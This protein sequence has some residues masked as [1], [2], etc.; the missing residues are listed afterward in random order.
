[1]DINKLKTGMREVN[2]NENNSLYLLR[3][4]FVF[5]IVL[6]IIISPHF[7]DEKIKEL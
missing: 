1:M 7:I 3:S 5:S 6:N 4:Q 2:N